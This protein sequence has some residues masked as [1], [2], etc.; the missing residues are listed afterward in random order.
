DVAEVLVDIGRARA[1]IDEPAAAETLLRRA[2][3]IQRRALSADSE[4]MVP[5]LTALGQL[6][7][8]ERKSAE[9]RPLLEE[10]ARIARSRLPERH[11]DRLEAE[12]ALGAV[13]R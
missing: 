6:L 3:A 9:A 2:V 4:A 10:A 7:G 8:R 12:A 1:A 13:S 5:T 11:V